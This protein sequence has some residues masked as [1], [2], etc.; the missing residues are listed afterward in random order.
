MVGGFVARLPATLVP[1]L[2]Q[3]PFLSVLLR[4]SAGEVVEPELI[5]ESRA[6]A[7]AFLARSGIRYIVV[8]TTTASTDLQQYVV[9]L[10]V[11]E[12]ETSGERRLYVVRAER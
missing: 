11:T 10:P 6:T 3:S 1:R 2:L 5:D 8:N 7:S 4:L 9:S 12:L